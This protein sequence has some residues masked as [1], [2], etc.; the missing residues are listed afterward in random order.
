MMPSTRQPGDLARP[1]REVGTPVLFVFLWDTGFIGA[2]LGLPY[3]GPL[4]FLA[5]RSTLAAALLVLLPLALC[6]APTAAQE[7]AVELELVLAVD[8]SGSIDDVEAAQQ[9]QGYVD[10]ITDPAVGGAV[11]S[12]PTGRIAVT[13][14]E[15]AG[16]LDQHVLVPW[17]L[18]EDD[19]SARTFAARLMQAPGQRGGL[20]SISDAIDFAVRLFTDNG[21]AG[22][23]QVIDI[24]G[25]GVSNHGRA[26][27]RARDDAVAL[28]IVINGLPL[29]NSRPQPM[30]ASTPT[31]LRLDRYY[32][33]NVIGGSGSFLVPA[34]GL[35]AFKD[36]V[37]KKLIIEIADAS[38]APGAVPRRPSPSG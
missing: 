6:L 12:T 22:R 30:G 26:V 10:A 3:A 11:R 23:R 17:T 2:K 34:P 19:T 27:P 9:R 7:V 21:F 14:M 1:L 20:T 28:G 31:K 16:P 29:L 24:S 13:Y 38:L 25:D 5:L 33:Q 8:A 36:A 18:I 15:W 4:T 32:A 35:G 37:L